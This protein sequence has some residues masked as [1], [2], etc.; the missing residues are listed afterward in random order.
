MNRRNA[1]PV[2]LG[3]LVA[4]LSAMPASAQEP[5]DVGVTVSA[6]SAIGVIWHVTPR[7]AVRPDLSFSFSESDAD[8]GTDINAHSFTLGGSVLFYTGRW[9]NLQTYVAPRLSYSWASSSIDGANE[10]LDSTQDGWSLSGTFGAQYLLGT[11]FAVFAEAGL[12]YASQTAETPTSFGDNERTTW[13]FGTR[14]LV[15]ATLYF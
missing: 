9:D 7:V 2:G 11:R 8:V 14:T 13:T 5:G 12:A 4:G 1:Y 15:G 6:P 10:S 3:V